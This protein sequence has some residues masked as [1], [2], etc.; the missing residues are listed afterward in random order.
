M[1]NVA[2]VGG[3][4]GIGSAMLSQLSSRANIQTIHA[5]YCHSSAAAHLHNDEGPA[6]LEL[7]SEGTIAS[8]RPQQSQA[9]TQVHWSQVDI[10]DESSVQRWLM[11][12]EELDWLINCAGFLHDA[13]TKPEKSITQFNPCDFRKN[14]DINCLANLLLAKYAGPRLKQS[15]KGIFASITAKVGSIEDN[16]LGG[17]YSYRAAK[18]AANMVL[19]NLSIEWQRTA[20]N[21]RVVALH[22]GTTDTG[23]SK[24]FQRGVKAEKLFSPSKVAAMLIAQ[25]DQ[26]HDFHSGRFIAYDGEELP[27]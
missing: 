26:L 24:P 11:N 12:I 6:A 9:S 1:I 25:L 15:S 14:M 16:R 7:A 10:S 17:W 21:I 19:K 4:G 18:A 13:D 23:L 3:S 5:T 27:W 2:L 22:P 20:P 8:T